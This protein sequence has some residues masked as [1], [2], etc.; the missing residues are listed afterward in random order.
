MDN[1]SSIDHAARW[2]SKHTSGVGSTNLMMKR[3]KKRGTDEYQRRCRSYIM[4]VSRPISSSKPHRS[5]LIR[6]SSISQGRTSTTHHGRLHEHS[7]HSSRP[8]RFGLAIPPE[9]LPSVSSIH[10]LSVNATH[11]NN[12]YLKS[13]HNIE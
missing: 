5:H 1:E 7:Q 13:R 12:L 9:R 3:W 10:F 6:T 2:V 8:G 11:T 4:V